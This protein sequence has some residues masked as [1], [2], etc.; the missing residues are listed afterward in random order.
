MDYSSLNMRFVSLTLIFLSAFLI[1]CS[2]DSKSIDNKFQ[3]FSHLRLIK[4]GL[5]YPH[6]QKDLVN[7]I[8]NKNQPYLK[9]YDRVKR[10]KQKLFSENQ[11]NALQITVNA[12]STQC[13]K[14]RGNDEATS[15]C[16]GASTALYFFNQPGDDKKIQTLFAN[17]SPSL[18]ERVID[19]N[20]TWLLNRKNKTQWKNW[21]IKLTNSDEFKRGFL[22]ILDGQESPDLSINSL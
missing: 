12:I 14:K 8:A 1:S 9:I 19:E 4:I 22:A 6:T 20:A 21:V 3:S 10:A 17:T 5:D 13:V 15:I 18:I 2:N 7:C 11:A 16:Q